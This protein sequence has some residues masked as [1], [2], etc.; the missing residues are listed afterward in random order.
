MGTLPE[1]SDICY[2]L[3]YNNILVSC[4]GFTSISNGSY[5]LDIFV[6]KYEYKV[7]GGFSRLLKKFLEEYNPNSVIAY[8]DNDYF[9]GSLY[10][11]LDFLNHN[12]IRNYL[13]VKYKSVISKEKSKTI[14]LQNNK[15]IPEGDFMK[16]LGYYQVYRCGNT[17]WVWSK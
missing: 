12:Q 11:K 1:Y 5:K 13:L 3:Y 2:G 16:E 8:S 6:S 4:I 10:P 7:H 15:E 17:H 9:L 14:P